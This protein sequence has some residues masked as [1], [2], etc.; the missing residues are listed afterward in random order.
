[1]L[2]IFINTGSKESKTEERTIKGGEETSE[3]SG[4][5]QQIITSLFNTNYSPFT[6]YLLWAWPSASARNKNKN[7]TTTPASKQLSI[8]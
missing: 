1:M 3:P 8:F 5:G 4:E 2:E 7:E 6:K